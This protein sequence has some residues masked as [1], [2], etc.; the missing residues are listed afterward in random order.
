MFRHFQLRTTTTTTTQ[1]TNSNLVLHIP[2]HSINIL[3]IFVSP[4][5]G[6]SYRRR[7]IKRVHL[8]SVEPVK[9]KALSTRTLSFIQPPRLETI[10]QKAVRLGICRNTPSSME[11]CLDVAAV[12]LSAWQQAARNQ[13][14]LRMFFWSLRKREAAL[15]Q[16]K[17]LMLWQRQVPHLS[18]TQLTDWRGSQPGELR[19]PLEPSFDPF[20]CSQVYY[21][22]SFCDC[23][24][25]MWH[26]CTAHL[27]N[28]TIHRR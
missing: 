15:L 5:L 21:C 25:C 26:E 7:Q 22:D 2:F 16:L 9:K 10:G 18:G 11:E 28:G 1:M 14:R 8:V 24:G 27:V 13:H 12:I 6:H 17:G 19:R 4:L 3:I 23:C 20:Y